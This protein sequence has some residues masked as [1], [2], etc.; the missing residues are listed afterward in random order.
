MGNLKRK[1]LMRDN[2]S[3]NQGHLNIKYRQHKIKQ[4]ALKMCLTKEPSIIH[5]KKS[6]LLK[7]RLIHLC[8]LISTKILY[9]LTRS[10]IKGIHWMNSLILMISHSLSSPRRIIS[11]DQ[12]ITMIT[13][14]MKMTLMK[15]I[16]F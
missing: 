11:M 16:T 4:T 15:K 9:L 3:R 10:K 1:L 5:L 6:N 13:K 2:K 8:K 12:W 14:N 7:L